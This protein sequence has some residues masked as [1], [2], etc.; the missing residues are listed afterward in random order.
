MNRFQGEFLPFTIL[1]FI[2]TFFAAAERIRSTFFSKMRVEK[3]GIRWST[4]IP[5][6]TYVAIIGVGVTEYFMGS[7]KINLI[8]SFLGLVIFICGAYLR[9]SSI[10]ALGKC[11][12]IHIDATNVQRV[13][14]DGPY[15]YVRHPY[16]LS[17]IFELAGFSLVCNSYYP[18]LFIF[19]IQLPLLAKR[20]YI[21]ERQLIKKFGEEYYT[22]QKEVGRLLPKMKAVFNGLN[23]TE[24][25]IYQLYDLIKTLGIR[26]LLRMRKVHVGM[27]KY[28]RNYMTSQCICALLNLGF[29]DKMAKRGRINLNLYAKERGVD[30]EILRSVCDYLYSLKILKKNNDDYMLD[31]KGRNIV[32]FS[33]GTFNFIYAYAPLFENL[34]SLLK[35][36]KLYNIHVLRRQKF[37]AKAS[38]DTEKWLPFPIVKNIIEKYR[39][40]KILD[41]GCGSGEFLIYLCKDSSLTCYGIDISK[42]AIMY[43][44]QLLNE[45]GMDGRIILSVCDIFEVEEI[46]RNWGNADVITCMFVLHEFLYRGN[47]KVIELLTKLKRYFEGKHLIICELCKK[48]AELLR[49]KPTA[50][51]EHHLFHALSNQR[52][53]T[54]SEWK[55]IF[56]RADYKLIEEKSFAFAGQCYFV[57]K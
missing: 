7:R 17:I 1:F 38:A 40:K 16:C 53:I 5:M 18:F 15:K 2:F 6:I 36:E 42:E 56:R 47:E 9:N 50:I 29:F 41:L 26:H 51:A 34:E 13:V 12:S 3:I 22:Y 57:I 32:T 20:M 25:N 24:K 49:R 48:S 30:T 31:S 33:L 37:V 10:R 11:W 52:I 21:E 19:F 14:K 54:A 8:M 39:F 4:Y 44:K 27:L 46:A 35:Q 55:N 23:L 43:G 45:K 28:A